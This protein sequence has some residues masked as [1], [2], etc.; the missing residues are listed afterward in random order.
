MTMTGRMLISIA[1][2]LLTFMQLY[3]KILPG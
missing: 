1:W 3:H 2:K